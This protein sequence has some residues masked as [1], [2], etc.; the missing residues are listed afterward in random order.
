MSFLFFYFSFSDDSIDTVRHFGRHLKKHILFIFFQLLGPIL[1][2]STEND[3]L[4]E[5]EVIQNAMSDY[6]LS[7]L[8][9]FVHNLNQYNSRQANRID[10][11]VF[12][13]GST[14]EN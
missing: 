8:L 13:H 7:R 1:Q 4:D 3:W 12:I 10:I 6:Y 2:E 5:E 11:L 14:N 9:T